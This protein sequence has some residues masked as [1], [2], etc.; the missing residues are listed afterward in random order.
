MKR[1]RVPHV[2]LGLLCVMYFITY[3][4]RINISSAASSIQ[5]EFGFSNT[6]LG[7]IF[8][9]FGYPYLVFQIVGGWF[10]DRFGA[11]KTLFW[12]GMVWGVATILTGLIGGFV[13][14]RFPGI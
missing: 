11:R 13:S 3:I 7:V 10:G 4:D 12:C 2:I 6:Q 9:M 1:F 14:L 5:D 8:S